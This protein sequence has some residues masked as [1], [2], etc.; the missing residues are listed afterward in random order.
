LHPRMQ[1]SSLSKLRSLAVLEASSPCEW[2]IDMF[3]EIEIDSRGIRL[4]HWVSVR[5]ASRP[6]FGSTQ[7]S[8]SNGERVELDWGVEFTAHMH[9]VLRL[10]L[11]QVTSLLHHTCFIKHKVLLLKFPDLVFHIVT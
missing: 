5:L 3:W 9:V 1:C 2:L 6:S 7:P 8:L 4:G 11:L 10:I